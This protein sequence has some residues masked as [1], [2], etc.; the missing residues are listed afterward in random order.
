[1]LPWQHSYLRNTLQSMRSF[2]IGFPL[3]TQQNKKL[4]RY[5]ISY[6]LTQT[7][8]GGTKEK[9]RIQVF[10][11]LRLQPLFHLSDGKTRTQHLAYSWN[12][13]AEG[14]NES[15]SLT[16][17]YIRSDELYGNTIFI[18]FKNLR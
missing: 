9:P 6:F 13:I 8:K 12:T 5:Q 10:T 7:L 14:M 2:Q 18:S 1:M 11:F 4:S 3:L 16:L 17:K 15:P